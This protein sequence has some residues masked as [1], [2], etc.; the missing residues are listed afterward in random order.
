MPSGLFGKPITGCQVYLAMNFN[1]VLVSLGKFIGFSHSFFFVIKFVVIR[2]M[3]PGNLT[4]LNGNV[5]TSDPKYLFGATLAFECNEGFEL[6]G[7]DTIKCLEFGW[8]S[9]RLPY[10]KGE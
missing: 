6:R 1:R 7:P 5:F 4:M 10:C 8:S 9:R 3:N 2:C